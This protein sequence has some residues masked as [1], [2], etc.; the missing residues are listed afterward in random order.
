[1]F[2]RSFSRN[3][4]DIRMADRILSVNFISAMC[5]KPHLIEVEV[6]G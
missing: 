1:M 2:D 4:V 5:V 3:L 6:R